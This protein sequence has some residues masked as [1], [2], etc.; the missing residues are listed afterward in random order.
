MVLK[1]RYIVIH[2]PEKGGLIP[3]TGIP[4]SADDKSCKGGL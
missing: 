4:V 3:T 2:N 1:R